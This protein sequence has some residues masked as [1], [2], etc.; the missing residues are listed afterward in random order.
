M[1]ELGRNGACGGQGGAGARASRGCAG[2]RVH[3]GAAL[4]RRS[5]VAGL[6]LFAVGTLAACSMPGPSKVAPATPQTGSATTDGG[7]APQTGTPATSGAG[8]PLYEV[9]VTRT[10]VTGSYDGTQLLVLDVDLTNNDKMSVPASVV[11][12]MYTQA[13]QGGTHLQEGYLPSDVPGALP[14]SGT[15]IEPGKTG[16]AQFVYEL[17]DTSP[18]EVVTKV[19]TTDYLSQVEVLRTTIDPAKA[20]KAQSDA[21]FDLTVDKAILTDDGAGKNLLVLEMT[22]TNRSDQPQSY[23]TATTVELY[24]NG[25]QLKQGS[26]PYK[27]PAYNEDESGARYT[28]VEKDKSVKLQNVWELTDPTADVKFT[29]KASLSYDQRVVV[30]KTIKIDQAAAATTGK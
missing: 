1:S 20:E 10:W 28:N 26:L 11:A 13:T 7:A 4:S 27:H 25:T 23:G 24:Q 17:K 6:G 15:S 14:S 16:K 18:V 22:F 3:G 2:A 12:T 30:S 8:T 19:D 29:A 21:G 9:K 5:F